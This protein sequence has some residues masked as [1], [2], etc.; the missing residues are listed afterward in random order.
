MLSYNEMEFQ[1]EISKFYRV[2]KHANCKACN[3]TVYCSGNISFQKPPK[4]THYKSC[5]CHSPQTRCHCQTHNGIKENTTT[6]HDAAACREHLFLPVHVC[7]RIHWPAR[8]AKVSIP[9]CRILFCRLVFHSLLLFPSSFHVNA[10]HINAFVA[11]G[12]HRQFRRIKGS[13]CL[14]IQLSLHV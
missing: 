5:L 3:C 13:V 14:S 2:A 8:L 11:A 4:W 9:W 10:S 1:R 7:F 6:P 12:T